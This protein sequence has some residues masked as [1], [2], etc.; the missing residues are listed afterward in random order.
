MK[1]LPG[2]FGG[3]PLAGPSWRWRQSGRRAR[4]GF[5]FL[6]S[7]DADDWGHCQGARCGSL[8]YNIIRKGLDLAPADASGILAVGQFFENSNATISLTGWVGNTTNITFAR[9]ASDVLSANLS[10]YKMLYIPSGY[11]DTDGGLDISLNNALISIRSRIMDFVNNRGGSLVALMQR[12]MGT[13]AL[14][15][16][17]IAMNFTSMEIAN[18]SVTQVQWGFK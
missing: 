10:N 9:N 14:G 5:V 4:G 7:D 3:G 1:L 16:L 6:S 11:S 13:K 17:P 12:G 18:V 2:A 8:Y 15:F